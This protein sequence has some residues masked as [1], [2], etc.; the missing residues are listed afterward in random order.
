MNERDM[1]YKLQSV[2]QLRACLGRVSGDIRVEV[3]RGLAVTAESAADLRSLSDLP[4]G[5]ILVIHDDPDPRFSM[6]RVERLCS[7]A[8]ARLRLFRG[9]AWTAF[10]GP[11]AHARRGPAHRRQHRQAAGVAARS[12]GT[13]ETTSGLLWPGAGPSAAKGYPLS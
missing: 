6:V 9:R 5:L 7:K 1:R 10:G 12:R 8:G 3:E 2:D 4:P 13:P 11:F